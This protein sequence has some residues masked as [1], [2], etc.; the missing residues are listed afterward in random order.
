[1]LPHSASTK[2]NNYHLNS[3]HTTSY[4]PYYSSSPLTNNTVS[5]TGQIISHSVKQ[6]DHEEENYLE[7][8]QVSNNSSNMTPNK[9]TLYYSQ[10]SQNS[11]DVDN[12]LS[13][14]RT[15]QTHPPTTPVSSTNCNNS[16][17]QANDSQ[18]AS[19]SSYRIENKVV[20]IEEKS[21]C[22]LSNSSSVTSISQLNK[23]AG[24]CVTPVTISSS[25]STVPLAKV[26]ETLD[27]DLLKTGA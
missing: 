16:L 20:V 8:D 14:V 11:S 25:S 23:E 12:D 13:S 7:F 5:V 15:P 9:F 2:R 4:H 22:Y 6:N 27:G 1:M 24:P 17:N 3:R 26:A 21:E 18:A 10:N 19:P